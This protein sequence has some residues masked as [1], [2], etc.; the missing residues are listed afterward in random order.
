MFGKLRRLVLTLILADAFL[1]QVALW[2]ADSM[3]RFLP[4]G[5]AIDTTGS[6]LNPY[7]YLIIAVLWP[8]VFYVISVYDVRRDVR[9]VGNARI[10]F[11][12]VSTAVFV[13][14][15]VLYFTF[16]DTPRLLIL[17]FY[18]FDLV[19]LAS[20]R[21]TV[22]L[23]L[24]LMHASGRPLTRILLVGAGEAAE[25]IALSLANRLGHGIS[26]IGCA[27]DDVV[28]GPLG[29]PV[30]GLVEDVLR[31]VRECRIDE[32]IIC[33]PASRYADIEQ[34]SFQLQTE[35]V[36]VRLVPDFLKLVMVQSSVELIGGLPLIG[37]REPRIDGPAWAVKRLFDLT[38]SVLLLAL[39]SPAMLLAALAVKL[40]SPG[41]VFYHQRRV[42][43]NG[44]LF[45]VHKF[46][47]MVAGAEQNRFEKRPDDPRVTHLGRLLRR[48]SIDELPQLFNVL[49]GE[50]SLVG[51]RPEQVFIVE[52]YEPWQR[53][54]L[55]V[56]PGITGWWQVN[57]RGDLPMHLNT[58]YDLYYIRNYSL[59]L[60]LKILWKTAGVV[61]KG[62][63]AY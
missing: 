9:P 48:T 19:L 10:L 32:V 1:T 47:T 3:R 35:P 54:R 51:P 36:R 29:I 33:L 15:G 61:I 56:P 57:G 13:L 18:L 7:I 5:R 46:R 23:V 6:F 34:L 16:R 63:G 52:Q 22:G 12:A 55:A 37:L 43:E 21:L 20:A 4:L 11:V 53:Q 60:D 41:P 24:R 40:T 44:K 30:L 58:H 49:R 59:W 14:S 42:G 28:E 45:W 31:L 25:A 38:L 26:I 2:V 50:M 17:Y 27:D 8:V 62:R 39:A